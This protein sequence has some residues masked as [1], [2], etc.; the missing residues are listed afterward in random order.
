[1]QDGFCK[2]TLL[3][4]LEQPTVLIRTPD[5]EELLERINLFR[6]GQSVRPGREE[7]DFLKTALPFCERM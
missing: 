1:V 3:S 7:S 2:S 6:T 5:R 4:L